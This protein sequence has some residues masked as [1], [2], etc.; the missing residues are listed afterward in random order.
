MARSWQ[1][2][3]VFPVVARL[4]GELHAELEDWVRHEEIVQALLDDSEGAKLVYDA[5]SPRESESQIA[6]NMVAWFSQQI[7]VK[8]SPYTD[9]FER[10]K[11]GGRYAYRPIASDGSPRY[12][13]EEL[14]EF[15]EIA[16]SI[17]ELYQAVTGSTDPAPPAFKALITRM[18][19]TGDLGP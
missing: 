17:E 11:L 14:R 1:F 16:E 6:A 8:E 19:R 13:K 18:V 5:C 2:S 4:I 7:T 9:A 12:D 15:A 3:D 10:T